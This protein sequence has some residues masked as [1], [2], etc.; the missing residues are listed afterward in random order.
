MT[1]ITRLATPLVFCST[2]LIAGCSDR[3]GPTALPT[4]S[5]SRAQSSSALDAGANSLTTIRW[6]EIARQLVAG[7]PFQ[8][9][10]APT[11]T[12]L[13]ALVSV[14]QYAAAVAA[15]GGSAENHDRQDGDSGDPLLRGA[16]ANASADVLT[17][18]FPTQSSYL[19]SELTSQSA[20]LNPGEA[21]RFAKGEEIGRAIAAQVISRAQGDGANAVVTLQIPVGPGYWFGTPVTP[22]WPAVRPWVMSSG[23]ALR[24]APPP[25]FGSDA[26]LAALAEVKAASDLAPDDPVRVEQLRIVKFW[27][28]PPAASHHSGHWNAIAAGY[29]VEHHFGELRAARTLALEN[30]AIADAA[31]ACMDAKY[32]YWF[33]R[34]YQADVAI[35]TP[36]GQPPHASY[37]S[38]HSCQ[39]GA[40]AGVLKATFRDKR[41]ELGA[42]EQEMNVSRI[43]AGLHYRF[44]VEVGLDMGHQAAELALSF[45]RRESVFD[46]LKQ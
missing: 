24:P 22:Q 46:L 23:S 2:V 13:Y 34:P 11:A 4:P 19:Q 20:G 36:I 17:Y 6:N 44:D 27:E 40:A 38:L 1:S 41:E 42:M 32:T 37:P 35:N 18:L 16:I 43:Y 39:T 21:R 3:S 26:F 10:R 9:P 12:R 5:L 8:Y 14:A 29:I 45:G 28:D 15:R 25:A 33:I 30:I 7:P 31:I